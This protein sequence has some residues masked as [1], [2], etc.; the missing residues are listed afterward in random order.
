MFAAIRRCGMEKMR[1][2]P[3]IPTENMDA[4]FQMVCYVFTAI[5]AFGTWL[6]SCRA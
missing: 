6:M 2:Y 3:M 5:T 4:A 1:M